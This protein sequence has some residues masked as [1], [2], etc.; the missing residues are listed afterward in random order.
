MLCNLITFLHV[1]SI[2]GLMNLMEYQLLSRRDRLSLDI[3]PLPNI[4]LHHPTLSR[5]TLLEPSMTLSLLSM[6][7][8]YPA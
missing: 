6:I 8:L 5:M 1:L 2:V 4:P 3:Y 7:L